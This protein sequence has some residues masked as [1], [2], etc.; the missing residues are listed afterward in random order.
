[1]S[2]EPVGE[3]H[4]PSAVSRH[5]FHLALDHIDLVVQER[6][7]GSR[8]PDPRGFKRRPGRGLLAVPRSRMRLGQVELD[9]VP[10]VLLA[11]D[12]P[13]VR[14]DL[15]SLLRTPQPALVQRRFTEQGDQVV[16][17]TDALVLLDDRFARSAP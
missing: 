10:D 12:P 7:P 4:R 11:P 1:M 9:L 3:L 8:C 5:H 17:V 2:L 13:G 14:D 6:H 15:E 16:A